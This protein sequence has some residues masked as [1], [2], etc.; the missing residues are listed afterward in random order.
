MAEPGVRGKRT[1]ETAADWRIVDYIPRTGNMAAT[2]GQGHVQFA[3][4]DSKSG[5]YSTIPSCGFFQLE[6]QWVASFLYQFYVPLYEY[7]LWCMYLAE[8]I[9]NSVADIQ[10]KI[11]KHKVTL[12]ACNS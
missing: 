8:R 4:G 5:K 3:T 11:T 12:C 7:L 6:E 9:D 2:R 10:Y 1:T